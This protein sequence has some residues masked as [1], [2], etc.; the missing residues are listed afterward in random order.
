MILRHGDERVLREKFFGEFGGVLIE[1]GRSAIGLRVEQSTGFDEFPDVVD[2]LIGQLRGDMAGEIKNGGVGPI[3]PVAFDADDLKIEGAFEFF[4][5]EAGEVGD[6]A[7]AV[8]PVAVEPQLVHEDRMT[9]ARQEEQGVGGG[10]FVAAPG[11]IGLLK[12]E[13]FAGALAVP[14]VLA[15]EF[16]SAGEADAF[17]AV[18][19][20]APVAAVVEDPIALFKPGERLGQRR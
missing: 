17:D 11:A 16:E 18:K 10:D 6:I 19:R 2:L 4:G 7:R 1:G 14:V 15:E 12:I 5:G 3:R 13:C 20:V 9:A 8:G